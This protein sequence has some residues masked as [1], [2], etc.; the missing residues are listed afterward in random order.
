MRTLVVAVLAATMLAGCSGG[1]GLS[2]HIVK[3]GD[4]GE[5]FSYWAL[6]ETARDA[7][8][9]SNP[10]AI[11]VS[12]ADMPG[13]VAAYFSAFVYNGTEADQY[14]D[15]IIISQALR[16][17][18]AT[19]AEMN[20]EAFGGCSQSTFIITQGTTVIYVN[21]LTFQMSDDDEE[22]FSMKAHDAAHEVAHRIGGTEYCGDE[23]H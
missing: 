13:L 10:G 15:P 6:D 2:N 4:L 1:D 21:A 18:N 5:G 12:D 17:N 11:D 7:G 3:K 19:N 22:F 20:V 8:I 14:D 16:W 9:R 23:S